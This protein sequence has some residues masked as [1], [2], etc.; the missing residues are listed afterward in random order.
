[1]VVLLRLAYVTVRTPWGAGES[2]ILPEIL[3]LQRKGHKVTVFP[4]R[5]ERSLVAGA[6]A[7]AVAEIAVRIPLLSLGVFFGGVLMGVRHPLLVASTLWTILRC[8]GS[9]RNILK[10]LLVFAKGL[11][12]ARRIKQDR[13]DHIHVH[14]ASTTATAGYIASKMS[15]IPWSFTAHRWD[16]TENNM[17]KEKVTTARFV[18][19]I[20]KAGASTLAQ[21]LGAG[22]ED[23]IRTIHMGVATGGGQAMSPAPA[24]LGTDASGLIACTANLLPVKGHRYLLQALASIRSHGLQVRCWLIGTGPLRAQLKRDTARLG[25]ESCVE[26]KGQLPHDELL[27]LYHS[28]LVDVVVLP[29][30][31]TEDGEHEGIPVS[32]ME[33][34]AAGI[35][36]V[37]TRTGA[38]P[39]LLEGGAGVL[40][41]QKDP[42]ALAEAIEL[43]IS[44]VS[45]RRCIGEAGRQRVLQEFKIDTVVDELVRLF[46]VCRVTL[47]GK[48]S[49]LPEHS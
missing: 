10:N 37:S 15:G 25:L 24:R 14:W 19:A 4:L 21:L 26:F 35:P 8:S 33:A 32:L 27:R 31:V 16:I 18:R 30:I 49:R 47:P 9:C 44:D 28:G 3:E 7:R 11:V 12:L 6:E 45:L 42:V 5:P 48:P 43:L 38:I 22:L 1:M 36:V 29:S 46:R 41:P 2:F 20:S 23:K 34:M 40:V 17:L 39:E 13:F